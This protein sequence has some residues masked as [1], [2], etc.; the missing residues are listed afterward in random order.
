MGMGIIGVQQ[1]DFIVLEVLYPFI[2]L[3]HYSP[4]QMKSSYMVMFVKALKSNVDI[5]VLLFE[6]TTLVLITI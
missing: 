5:L 3:L 4:F 1:E 2:F 6:T